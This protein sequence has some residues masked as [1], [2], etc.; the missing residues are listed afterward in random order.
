MQLEIMMEFRQ[1]SRTGW[2]KGKRRFSKEYLMR[3]AEH[4]YEEEEMGIEEGIKKPKPSR[5]G[6]LLQKTKIKK[7][8]TEGRRRGRTSVPRR[9]D[10]DIGR[11]EKYV[12]IG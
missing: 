5:R 12:E 6:L 7:E 4:H 10:M 11:L 8:E 3:M 1:D 9:A 2:M